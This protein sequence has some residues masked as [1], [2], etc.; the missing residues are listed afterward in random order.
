MSSI[1]KNPAP[2]LYSNVLIEKY[3]EQ[4]LNL[5][6]TM[7]SLDPFTDKLIPQLSILQIIIKTLK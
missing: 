1:N 4:L 6:A 2:Y 7:T 3:T 5:M